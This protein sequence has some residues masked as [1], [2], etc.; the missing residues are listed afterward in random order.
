[1][2]AVSRGNAHYAESRKRKEAAYVSTEKNVWH[3]HGNMGII[4]EMEN[5]QVKYLWELR[6][7]KSSKNNGAVLW[8]SMDF[9]GPIKQMSKGGKRR[10]TNMS[11]IYIQGP[12]TMAKVVM[13]TAV[14]DIELELWAKETAKAYRN[15]IQ[16]CMEGY[17]DDTIFHRIIKGFITQDG[18]PTGT[19]EG[20]KIYGEPFK[21]KFH[22]G[23][24]FCRRDLI[25]IANAGN[26][27][28]GSQFLFTLSSTPDLQNKHTIF[29]KVIGES[30]HSMF[31]LEEA[32]NDRLLYPPRLLK[33]IILNY[34][35]SDIIPRIIV[36][37]CEEVKDSSKSKTAAVKNF[38][39]LSF[40]EEADEDEEESVMLNKK[41]SCKGKSVHDH[42]IPKLSSQPAVESLGLEKIK[43][44]RK[45]IVAIGK[46]TTK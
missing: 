32:L 29:G 11:N 14:G 12:P 17:W 4:E 19:G 21:A 35:F 30:I 34:P 37:E 39:L 6:K 41:F 22:T 28:N 20:G 38:N 36:H 24:H 27:D 15:F 18:D 1:M 31:K 46:V 13:K 8:Q 43:K 45:T 7:H 26:D 16:L 5:E 42:L 2:K 9:I 10:L 25:A 44:G 40:G 33:S 3:R 23:L